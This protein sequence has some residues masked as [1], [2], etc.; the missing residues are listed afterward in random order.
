MGFGAHNIFL[1]TCVNYGNFYKSLFSGYYK[2]KKKRE[3]KCFEKIVISDPDTLLM[4]ILTRLDTTQKN[5]FF[6]VVFFSNSRSVV[7]AMPGWH[8]FQI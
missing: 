6:V 1:E 3:G 8:P 5:I 4:S 2:K 7:M